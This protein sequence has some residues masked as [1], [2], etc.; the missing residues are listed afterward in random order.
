ML[1]PRLRILLAALWCFAASARAHM[2]IWHPSMYGVGAGFAYEAGGSPVDPLG[3]GLSTQD[4]WWF[5]GPRAR[6]L[7]PQEGAV[8][9]LPAGGSLTFEIA[10]HYAWTSYGYATSVPGSQLDACPGPNAG[11][12]HAGDPDSKVIDYNLVSGCALAIADVDDISKVTMDNLAIF[13][14]QHECVQQKMTSFEVPARMP[15]CTGSKCI[16]GWFWLANN[17]TANFYMTAF[18]CAVTG[19]PADATPIAPPQDPVFCKNDPSSCTTGAKRPIYAY[20]NPTNVPWIGNDDRAG[21]HASWSFGTN[22]AQND[23]FRA[24]ACSSQGGYSN[25]ALTASGNH[26]SCSRD[27]DSDQRLVFEHGEEYSWY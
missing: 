20:N 14:V 13:S 11:P 21:Y 10:C 16:C 3:P 8:M 25:T 22:G 9:E 18:D 24:S 2:S 23:I 17:G 1:L 4:E 7:P 27:L 15:K 19:S 5:R 6:A 12:Y 26:G